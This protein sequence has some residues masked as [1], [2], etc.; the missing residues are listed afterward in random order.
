MTYTAWESA[1]RIDTMTL[2]NRRFT[3]RPATAAV[4]CL[5]GAWS[6]AQSPVRADPP[7]YQAE[8]FPALEGF[9]SA[10]PI[11]LAESGVIVGYAAPAPTEP[12][13]VAVATVGHML[14]ELP[15]KAEFWR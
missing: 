13:S 12:D 3:L 15:T 8:V 10:M 9:D 14:I 4:L 7:F 6:L 5:V 2:Q 1:W 11:A